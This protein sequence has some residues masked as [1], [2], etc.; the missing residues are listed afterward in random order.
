VTASAARRLRHTGATG[1]TLITPYA[2]G[3]QTQHGPIVQ[4]RKKKKYSRRYLVE[5]GARPG[6]YLAVWM[7]HDEIVLTGQSS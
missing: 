2:V 6:A 5:L 1:K 3:T 4:V 7:R